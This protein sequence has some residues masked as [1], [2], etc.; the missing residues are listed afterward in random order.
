VDPLPCA[1]TTTAQPSKLEAMDRIDRKPIMA[2]QL[3]SDSSCVDSR[4]LSNCVDR[5]EIQV[6]SFSRAPG[7]FPGVPGF[8]D[9]VAVQ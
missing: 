7:A 5:Y 9:C 2:T 4:E 1:D 3:C 6:S 8:P